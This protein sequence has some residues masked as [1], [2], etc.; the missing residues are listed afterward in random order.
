MFT[1]EQIGPN[2]YHVVLDTDE[3]HGMNVFF[4]PTGYRTKA[5]WF[6]GEVV[7]NLIQDYVDQWKFVE[8]LDYLGISPH[9]A[10]NI[11]ANVADHVALL[12]ITARLTS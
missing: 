2:M 6:N 1:L 8:R 12:N 10:A 7:G 3:A 4:V 5:V 9:V 11:R